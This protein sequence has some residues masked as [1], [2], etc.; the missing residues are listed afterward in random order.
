MLVPPAARAAMN[1]ACKQLGV[2][3][4]WLLERLLDWFASQPPLIKSMIAMG[5][6]MEEIAGDIRRRAR[7]R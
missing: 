6:P 2:R 4:V 7:G 1:K 5:V 3:Q